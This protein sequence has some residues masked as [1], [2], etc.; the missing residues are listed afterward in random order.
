MNKLKEKGK[1]IMHDLAF[2]DTEIQNIFDLIAEDHPD[3]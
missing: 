1:Q 3:L 2:D